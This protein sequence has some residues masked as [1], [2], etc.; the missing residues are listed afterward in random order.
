LP[1]KRGGPAREDSLLSLQQSHTLLQAELAQARQR[2]AQR[3]TIGGL[4]TVGLVVAV[5]FASG[6]LAAWTLPL[7]SPWIGE[8]APLVLPLLSLGLGIATGGLAVRMR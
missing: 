6:A 1:A 2:L 3:E 7:W 5:S 8:Q 4:Q